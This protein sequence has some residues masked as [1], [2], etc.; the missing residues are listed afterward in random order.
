MKRTLTITAIVATLALAGCSTTTPGTLDSVKSDTQAPVTAPPAPEVAPA[1]EPAPEPAAP[2]APE[3]T[4]GQQNAI[5]SANSYLRLMGFSRSGLIGQ[6]EYEG[7]SVEDAT[8]A[9]DALAPDWYAEAAESAQSYL[10][11]MSFSRQGLID[12][13]LYEGFSPEEAEHGVTAV[14]Y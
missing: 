10:D 9:V 1:P 3:F 11:V 8:F 13:L 7:Y 2:P 6:L 14:G 12:Q 4:I 5:D